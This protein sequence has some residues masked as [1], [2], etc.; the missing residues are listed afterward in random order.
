ML[1]ILFLSIMVAMWPNTG[2]LFELVR[3]PTIFTSLVVVG[4]GRGLYLLW[5]LCRSE[6]AMDKMSERL[7]LMYNTKPLCVTQYLEPGIPL[8]ISSAY[9]RVP[10]C[11]CLA[12]FSARLCSL[13]FL[14]CSLVS[15]SCCLSNFVCARPRFI[16][17]SRAISR[18]LLAS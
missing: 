4:S 13:S 1:L 17:C 11:L 12:F 15:C 18:C 7:M 9:C 3:N 5:E 2:W 8:N 14:S 10:Y 6:R 16:S